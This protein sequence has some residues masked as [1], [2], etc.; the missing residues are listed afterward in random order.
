MIYTS[1]RVSNVGLSRF[2]TH[3]LC[4]E[5]FAGTNSAVIIS[6]WAPLIQWEL[7]NSDLPSD[8]VA[9][10]RA[11]HQTMQHVAAAGHMF[12]K[13]AWRMEF[14]LTEDIILDTH[15]LLTE[16]LYTYDLDPV[17][18]ESVGAYRTTPAR[19]GYI[20]YPD[21]SQVPRLMREMVA[22][23]NAEI[24]QAT[25][26][27][28]D[29]GIVMMDPMV[30]AAKYCHKF[31]AIHPFAS[32]NGRMGRL[33]LNTLLTKYGHMIVSFGEDAQQREIYRSIEARGWM[34]E[35]AGRGDLDPN[36]SLKPW[37]MLA[38]LTLA[39]SWKSSGELYKQVLFEEVGS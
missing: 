37:K 34:R 33:I 22:E 17:R 27:V 10:R 14:V 2:I 15:R 11:Y 8:I 16:K 6:R 13:V 21:A 25:N 38:S 7:Q 39:Q 29:G 4:E 18:S 31:L 20:G 3:H 32:G 1:N 9:V 26:N 28:R 35:S 19:A 5:F 23:L 24:V 30:L 12:D 36:T